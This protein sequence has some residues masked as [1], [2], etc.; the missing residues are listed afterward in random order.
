[1]RRRDDTILRLGA[2]GDNWHMT[3]TE[4]GDQLAALC[5]GLGWPEWPMDVYNSRL[6]R[7]SGEPQNAVFGKLDGYPD[8]TLYRIRET[9]G[10]YG[11]G[12]VAVG[13]RIIQLLA[14]IGGTVKL[15]YSPDGGRTWCNQDGSSPVVW[16]P[17]SE[18]S[19]DTM[20]FHGEPGR[21]FVLPSILQMGQGYRLNRD[22]YL[23][24]YSPNG[25]TEGTMNQ[26]VMCR[27]LIDRFQDR[28]AYEFYAGTNRDGFPA[29]SPDV[30]DRVPVHTFP[31]G[32]VNEGADGHPYAWHPSL[33]YNAALDTYMM[34][35]WG[36]GATETGGMFGKPGYLGLWTSPT[37]WGPW[38]QVHEDTSWTPGDD[39]SA[40]CYQPQFAPAWI[41]EDGRSFWL[42]W[43]D[44]QNIP[45]FETADSAHD[46]PT[47][48]QFVRL[49]FQS[50]RYQPF[51]AFNAQQ[52]EILVE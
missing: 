15:I 48:D 50:R 21:A 22:G 49:W 26:L 39:A 42:V 33:A 35:N 23:Y 47:H 38:T 30:D 7:V 12:T 18:Q 19:R 43:T 5:D 2:D 37:P 4:D 8:K 25:M 36:M 32:W 44:F 46:A 27:V 14:T 6:I 28:D 45:A 11:F 16:E 9:G 41:A 17:W 31:S 52:V 24:I 29:W 10:Y 1:M 40:R 34:L 51:Y 13:E 20:L 3:W